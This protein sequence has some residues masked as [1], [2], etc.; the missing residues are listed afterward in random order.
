[1]A[2][3]VQKIQ[4]LQLV[5]QLTGGVTLGSQN[6]GGDLAI[7][8]PNVPPTGTGQALSVVSLNGNSV[9]LGWTTVAAPPI[10]SFSQITGSLALSQIA[11]G[12]ATS[13]QALEWNGTAWAPPRNGPWPK[14][15]L[16]IA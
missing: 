11:Q 16:K 3:Q 13:G 8:F 4:L 2:Q 7:L 9:I 6:I 10:P 12:G 1:M 5:G 14:H 15:C